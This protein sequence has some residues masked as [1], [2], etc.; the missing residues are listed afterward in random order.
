MSLVP[1]KYHNICFLVGIELF[2]ASKSTEKVLL[3]LVQFGRYINALIAL[4]YNT[5]RLCNFS[6]SSL[7]WNWSLFTSNERQPWRNWVD[8]ICPYKSASTLPYICWQTNT[9]FEQYFSI[10]QDNILFFPN[11]S[12]KIF[13]FK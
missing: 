3:G 7:R 8:A 5:S 2:L 9:P 10:S 1:Q 11:I 13:L 4:R 12:L 6:F